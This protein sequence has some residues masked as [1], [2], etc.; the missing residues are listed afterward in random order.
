MH[1]NSKLNH[2]LN[3]SRFDE[4]ALLLKN[5]LAKAEIIDPS[6]YTSWP[7]YADQ[8]SSKILSDKGQDALIVFWEDLLKFFKEELEPTWGHLH[9]GHIL[10]RLGLANLVDDVSI[11]KSY[12]EKALDEDRILEKKRA[13]GR[14]INIEKAVREYSAYV[15]LCIIERIEDEHFDS[16]RE[17][18]KFFQE[19]LS[20]SFDAAIM[21]RE[22]KP[23]LVQNVVKYIVP[24]Q[25][26]EQTLET[27]KELD[28][29]SAR[30]LQIS[31]IS[32]TGSFLENIL[33]SILY[34]QLNLRMV[35]GKNILEAELGKLLK[36]AIERG[37]FPSDSIRTTC[38]TIHIFRN[39]LHPGNEVRQKYKL[40]SRVAVTLKILLD[41]ALVEWKKQISKKKG[42]QASSI[43]G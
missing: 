39:R 8:I 6:N 18:Q 36:E 30:Q 33:L 4:A 26:L 12:L 40:T 9:K 5:H 22:V 42:E 25:G 24:Q 27:R 3:N 28:L 2:L 10:F 17:K 11:A 16:D 23:E 14:S 43:S 15:M 41:L 20:T 7:P 29:V 32:L 19:L 37:V 34:Y 21:R 13:E 1:K 31:T 35:Q 38:K